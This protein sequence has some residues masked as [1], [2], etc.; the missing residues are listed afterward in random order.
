MLSSKYHLRCATSKGVANTETLASRSGLRPVERRLTYVL[1]F[2]NFT[3]FRIDFWCAD[4]FDGSGLLEGRL[5]LQGPGKKS[6]RT[7]V[8]S[9]DVKLR[10]RN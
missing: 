2:Y 1:A 10:W 4:L 9:N 5:C 3:R 6:R 7:F 8:L